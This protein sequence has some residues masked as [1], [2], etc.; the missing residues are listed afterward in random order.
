MKKDLEDKKVLK[1][2]LDVTETLVY[3]DPLD[4]PDL[5]DLVAMEVTYFPPDKKDL[6]L[7]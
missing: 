1:D 6:P 2:L 4:H 5:L 7:L 3:L